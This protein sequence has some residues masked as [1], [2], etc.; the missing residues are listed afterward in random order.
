MA[1]REPGG[2]VLEE[3]QGAAGQV[4]ELF[5]TELL[6]TASGMETHNI[7]DFNIKHLNWT[8]ADLLSSNQ[9]SKLKPLIEQLFTRIFPLGVKQCVNVATQ[10]WPG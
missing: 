2:Q 9:T 7:G 3:H 10:I 6:R 5:R 4:A 1:V 8:K